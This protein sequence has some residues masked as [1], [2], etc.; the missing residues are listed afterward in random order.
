MSPLFA[1][2]LIVAVGAVAWMMRRGGEDAPAGPE[3]G[4]SPAPDDDSSGAEGS[5]EELAV[6]SEGDVFIPDGHS[7]RVMPLDPDEMAA[8]HED[9]EAGL[10]ALSR[11]E[12]LALV[13]RRGKPGQA[14]QAGDL[15]AA[16]IKR[17][18]AGV[19]PW[20]LETLGRDG[21]YILFPFETE[22]GAR[23][24]LDLLQGYGVVR[25]PRDE[26]G[27]PIPP[28]PEDFEEARRR[29]DESWRALAMENEPG[30][31][32]DPGT[33]SDRR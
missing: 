2:G 3:G 31:G 6:T 4:A 9:V 21:E 11:E 10:F 18:A 24:A 16:R 1:V 17:G 32:L 8:H 20:R 27:A 28:S 33:H 19:V 23:A 5:D 25:R 14:L 15:T 13:A 7:V 26:D 30:E 22:D 12:R 29:Y